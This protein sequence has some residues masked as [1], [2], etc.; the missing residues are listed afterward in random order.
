MLVFALLSLLSICAFAEP[1]D[2]TDKAAVLN[3][4]KMAMW[5][6][7][8]FFKDNSPG[9]GAWQETYSASKTLIQWHESGIYWGFFYDYFG[10]TGDS[11]FNDWVD[12]QMQQAVGPNVG[13]LDEITKKTGRWN[14]DIGWWAL[15]VMSAAESTKDGILAPKNPIEGQNPRYIDVVN[16]TF[17]QMYEQWDD[18]CGGGMFWSRDRTT[19]KVNDAYYK[20]SITNAQ[21]VDMGARLYAYTKNEMYREYVDRVYTWMLSS[22]LIDPVTY[23]VA[24]G[25]DSRACAIDRTLFSYHS[26]ELMSGLATMY[27]ATGNQ[28][29]LDEAHKHFKHVASHFTFENVLYD[30]MR[31]PAPIMPNGFMWPVYRGIGVL[32]SIT[33]DDSIKAQIRTIMAASAAF[34]FQPCN[35]IWYCI[36]DLDPSES[37]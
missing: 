28:R 22:T 17:I 25:L 13:F 27:K 32:Y 1:L 29:Y 5:P 36:R 2:V 19:P 15:G 6:L 18:S 31:G 30:P 34:N 8:M 14:D 37:S 12:D 26:G 10:L 21:H 24:D 23:A 11:Q 16:T 4:Y 20:S 33:T 7:K 35:S 3:A 9:L